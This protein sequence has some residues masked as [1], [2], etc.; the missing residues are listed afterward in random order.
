MDEVAPQEARAHEPVRGAPTRMPTGPTAYLF[1]R[2]AAATIR[3]DDR[4]YGGRISGPRSRG[5]LPAQNRRPSAI[6]KVGTALV[7]PADVILYR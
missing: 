1:T 3:K 2:L 5:S 4:V 6:D 7:L